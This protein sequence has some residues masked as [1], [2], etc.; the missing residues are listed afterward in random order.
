MSWGH[1]FSCMIPGHDFQPS[2][3][4]EIHQPMN[5][6]FSDISCQDSD[7]LYITAFLRMHSASE[8]W[9]WYSGIPG[10]QE[11]PV[12]SHHND[13]HSTS[14]QSVSEYLGCNLL[15]LHTSQQS[16]SEDWTSQ[17]NTVLQD[18]TS[19]LLL[20]LLLSPCTANAV[21]QGTTSSGLTSCQSLADLLNPTPAPVLQSLQVP[22]ETK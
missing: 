8:Y 15:P 21:A 5:N 3:S 1:D 12:P 22:P 4:L 7:G 6:F 20:L 13:L 18:W 17:Q 19:N 9:P 2:A 14:Q 16:A 11:P 10:S